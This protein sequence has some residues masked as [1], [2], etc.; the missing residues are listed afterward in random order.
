MK[1]AEKN[2]KR[3]VLLVDDHPLVREWLTSLINQESDLIVC[4]EASGAPEALKAIMAAQPD[5]VVVDITLANGSGLELIKDLK[6]CCPRVAIVVLSMH[7]E[8]MYAERALRA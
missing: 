3:K 6:V 2:K 7:D 1:T 8:S 4:G 5:A